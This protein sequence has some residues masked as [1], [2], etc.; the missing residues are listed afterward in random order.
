MELVVM[1]DDCR[2]ILDIFLMFQDVLRLFQPFYDNLLIF[3]NVQT[4]S[5]FFNV[6]TIS[7]PKTL[8]ILDVNSTVTLYFELINSSGSYN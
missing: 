6:Q 5:F 1:D 7:F 8:L 4:I 3:F 2:I